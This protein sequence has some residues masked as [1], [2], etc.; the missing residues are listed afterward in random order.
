MNPILEAALFRR[1]YIQQSNR[2]FRIPRIFWYLRS[3]RARWL[4]QCLNT[5]AWAILAACL[6]LALNACTVQGQSAE[7]PHNIALHRQGDT[8][9]IPADSPLRQQLRSGEASIQ[10]LHDSLS[11][12]ASVEAAPE[13]LVR[14][15]PP[16][17]GRIVRLHVQNGDSVKRGDLLV[18]LDSAEIPAL[19]GEYAKA[20]SALRQAEQEYARQQVLFDAEIAARRELEAAQLELDAARADLAAAVGALH[21]FGISLD[22]ANTGHYLMRAPIS[23]Q[24]LALDGAPGSYWNDTSDP[25]MVIADLR[26]L[27]LSAHVPEREIARIYIGQQANISFSARPD[28]SV[29][30]QVQYIDHVI[31][32]E[33]RS[34][35][36]RVALDNPDGLLRPGM[37]AQLQ[38]AAPPRQA[39]MIPA[40]ALLQGRLQSQVLVQTGEGEFELREVIAGRILGDQLEI[41]SGLA[42]GERVIINA[43]EML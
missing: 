11:A 14:I 22:N 4:R 20:Q 5:L 18:S 13:S 15:I 37:F 28:V 26:R 21:Q 7:N 25:L 36:V 2:H 39:V 29:T 35:K 34:V 31:D 43:V 9:M 33:S 40:S 30:G 12:V 24:V 27:W 17:T 19:R 1:E 6:I 32:P 3:R 23:G 8:L 16:V 42:A 41:R 10:P 38:F